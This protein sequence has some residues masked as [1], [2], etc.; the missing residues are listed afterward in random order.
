ML[1]TQASSE[2]LH[3]LEPVIVLIAISSI[4]FWRVTLRI[5]AIALVV[6]VVSGAVL[7]WTAMQH[8]TG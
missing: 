5:L 6:L 3:S 2:S 8:V 7:A 4:V 1:L